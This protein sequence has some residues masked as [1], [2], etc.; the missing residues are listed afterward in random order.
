[1]SQTLRAIPPYP[2][3]KTRASLSP[4]QQTELNEAI[5]SGLR[6]V[7]ELPPAQRD[8]PTTSAFLAT[9]A[10]DVAHQTL[11]DLIWTE[12]GTGRSFYQRLSRAEKGIRHSVFLLAEK[13]AVTGSLQLQTLVDLSVVYASTNPSRVRSLFSSA[14][15]HASLSEQVERELVPA[16]ESLLSNHS[17]GL[18]GIRKAAHVV[19]S[20]IRPSP[21]EGT[22]SFSRSKSFILALARA[23]D[24]GLLSL[25]QSY[26]GFRI[27]ASSSTRPLDEWERV[28]LETKV[29]LLDVFHILIT[30]LLESVAVVPSAGLAL[31][32]QCEPAFEVIFALLDVQPSQS[33]QETTPFLDRPLL[34]DYQH[35]YDLS[36]VLNDV[37]RR[38]DDART[39]HLAATLRS[40][41]APPA[42][43]TGASG[44]R[45]ASPKSGALKLL[46]S[47]SG[48]PPGIDN[49]GNGTRMPSTVSKGKLR[50]SPP[51]V[52][53]DPELDSAVLQILD[54][55]PEQ[56]P[57]YIRF[58]LSHSDYAYKRDAERLLDA[59]FS[60]TAPSVEEV[61]AAMRASAT[62]DEL[63][64]VNMGR[65]A[66]DFTFTKERRNVFDDE[67]VDMNLLHIGKKEYVF[68]LHFPRFHIP[69]TILMRRVENTTSLTDRAFI[70]EMKSNILR[71][72]E[73]VSDSDSE[74]NDGRQL[75]G[76]E[77]A[78]EEELDDD[79]GVLVRDGEGTDDDSED[80]E[81][82]GGDG[83]VRVTHTQLMSLRYSFAAGGE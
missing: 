54:V 83:A 24:H 81:Q 19:L 44:S 6:K 37:L 3:S 28:F 26:G 68:H 59:L 8:S 1:M 35:A 34:A 14:F 12:K 22:L 30:A 32:A 76:K 25:S 47:S 15:E 50:A 9:Y 4:S 42:H 16:F 78:F 45:G 31:A 75:K 17:Q 79:G 80:E 2:S 71:L 61:E 7:L 62:H 56:S 33:G 69:L 39:D 51:V 21:P 5:S 53:D 20:F 46:I 49:L 10:R 29:D 23:Y 64:E 66:D 72:A 40:L 55:L 11:Q 43:E 70:D 18:Y 67:V 41:D 65:T 73:A 60:G 74:D 58:L 77:V 27:P 52:E 63:T 13:M 82:D 38:V 48:V 57:S 36:S